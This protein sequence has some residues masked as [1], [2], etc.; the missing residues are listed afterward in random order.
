MAVLSD[1]GVERAHVVGHDWGAALGW[2]FASLV[3]DRV[4]HLAVLSVGP[5][6][7]ITRIMA[8]SWCFLCQLG[9][10]SV[11]VNQAIEDLPAL[12]PG[13]YIDR[14]AGFVQRRSLLP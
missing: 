1:A 14:L 10:S 7:A 5:C 13:G 2:V 12:D 3:P 8:L 6:R 11:L 9:C 4:D